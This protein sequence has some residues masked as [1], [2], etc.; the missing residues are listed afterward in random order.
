LAEIS[1][2]PWGQFGCQSDEIIDVRTP[3][4]YAEDHIPGAI[5]LPVLDDDEH[6]VV[7]K[8]YKQVS[9]FKARKVG[10][11]LV[12]KNISRHLNEHFAHKDGSYQ[13]AV[14]C[15]RGGQRSASLATILHAVGW[16]TSLLER[17][18]KS[19]RQAVVSALYDQPIEANFLVV[20]GN[21]G[22]G[23]TAFL[24]AVA[25]HDIHM[26]DLEACAN[27]RGSVLGGLSLGAQPSQKMFESRIHQILSKSVGGQMILVEAE[28]TKIGRLLLPPSIK[29]A[30]LRAPAIMLEASL[31][32][33]VAH[34]LA[35]YQAELLSDDL[36]AKKL[37]HLRQVRGNDRVDQWVEL[38]R[39]RDWES[40]VTCLLRDHYDPA[41]QH[42][43]VNRKRAFDAPFCVL[44][45]HGSLDNKKV[46][47]LLGCLKNYASSY[48]HGD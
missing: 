40:L 10:A 12:S 28:S 48:R 45:E 16:R 38:A 29:D 36:V 47:E 19:Y 22:T 23:K 2:Q 8:I 3:S 41:Y 33:R 32:V 11:A 5:N 6:A 43:R 30:L 24:H 20:D 27:H 25:E 37:D 26:L 9:P 34:L 39:M 46:A 42:G 17:G 7:G 31:K 21:T 44:H 15:W 18:Y 4:E 1:V 13:P 14:Y 35:I